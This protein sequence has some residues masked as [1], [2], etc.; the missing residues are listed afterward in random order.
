M[1]KYSCFAVVALWLLTAFGCGADKTDENLAKITVDEP[2]GI[3]EVKVMVL[4]PEVFAHDIVSNGKVEAGQW[5]DLRFAS[6]GGA[7]IDRIMVKNGQH[8]SKGQT[9]ATLDRFRLENAVTTA[10]NTLERSKLDLADA[11]IGQGYDPEKPSVVPDEVM[12]LARLR[13]GMAQAEVQLRESERALDDATLKAPFDGLV[14]NL[15]QKAGNVPDGQAFCR[16]MATG[17]MDVVFPI[18]E[19]ELALVHPGDAVEIKPFTS[20]RVYNGR[21][22]SINPVVDK[23]GMVSVCAS[24][25]G[26][27]GLYDGMNVRVSVKREIERAL[28]VPKSA[29]VL[30]SNGRQVV[31]THK[32][33]KAMWNYVTTGLE[34]MS[35][36]VI[37]DGLGEGQ[38][39]IVSG[40]I[41]LAHEAP[42]KVIGD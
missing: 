4:K 11:L 12:R 8:V 9:I 40:N 16:V 25:S 27:S 31:F 29:V 39:V 33:G 3:A 32:D 1:K 5:V 17:G 37:T 21:V 14:A 30:R 22:A 13:S 2:E 20:D 7:V 18:L 35:S 36:Y 42:V 23:N 38:E 24:V 41:N 15:T 10:R 19:S 28:V 34:N 6:A 26:G